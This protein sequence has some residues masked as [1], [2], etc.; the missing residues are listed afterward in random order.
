MNNYWGNSDTSIKFCEQAYT[1]SKFIAEYYNTL[2]GISYILVALPYLNSNINSIA[3]TSI[4]LGFGTITLHMTQRYYGQVIDELSML[5]VCYLILN[6]INNSRY[7]KKIIP[8]LLI[9]Y[10]QNFEKFIIFFT[11]FVGLVSLLIF[12]SYKMKIKNKIHQK[13]FLISLFVGLICWVL[14]QQFCYYV[15]DYNLHSIWHILTSVSLHSGIRLIKD[16]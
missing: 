10:I 8:F 4:C 12:E 7:P 13:I 11:N 9:I 16:L 15:R 1:Q 14:D 3:I 5:L 6:R 2:S